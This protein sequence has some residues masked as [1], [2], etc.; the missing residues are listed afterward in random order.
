MNKK[1]FGRNIWITVRESFSFFCTNHYIRPHFAKYKIYK[2]K[3]K[4]VFSQ[5]MKCDVRFNTVG[6]LF[7][8]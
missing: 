7:T 5:G 2:T 4:M 3:S 6:N 1:M 8:I